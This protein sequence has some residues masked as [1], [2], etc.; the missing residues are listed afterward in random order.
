M[1]NAAALAASADQDR[2]R[3]DQE[4]RESPRQN[5][6]FRV[7]IGVLIVVPVILIFAMESNTGIGFAA[8]ALM[9]ILLFIRLPIAFAL[10][11]PGLIGLYSMLGVR[12]VANLLGAEPLT[13]ASSWSLSVLPMFVLMGLLLARSGLTT[14]M[15]DAARSWFS[16]LPGGLAIGTNMSGAGLAAVSG[17]TIGTTYAL[18]RAGVP[19][20]FRAGY[21]KPLVI[22]SVIVAGLPGQ[23]IPPSI[24]LIVVA[25]IMENPVGPQLIAGILPGLTVAVFFALMIMVFSIIKPSWAGRGE[26][27]TVGSTWATRWSTLAATWPL[28][29]LMVVVIGG[30]FGGFFTATEAGAAGAAGALI[31]TWWFKRKDKPM[32]NIVGAAVETVSAVGSIFLLLVG[33]QILT[34]LV[35]VSGMGRLFSDFVLE[36]G[37]GRIEFLLVV[38]VLYIILGMFMDPLAILLTTIPLLLPVMQVLEIDPLWF[39]VFAVFMGE[40]AILTPPVGILSFIIH[41]LLQDPA[42]NLGNKV[43][44]GDVFKAVMLFLPMAILI[45]IIWILF[46]EIVTWLPSQ[47]AN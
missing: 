26:G 42:V 10:A 47:M 12:P 35:V 11:V 8:L 20:M 46:P 29:V 31:F 3:F 2:M 43:T 34:A 28:I 21:K 13:A 38:M 30:M 40:L 9:F 24:F 44:L 18:A 1:T 22:G 4:G 37:L 25:G 16:W 15:Y 17:S 6:L 14:S 32:K 5:W 23:L 19:E 27:E 41:K 39:G 7:A 33:A 36:A 45:T